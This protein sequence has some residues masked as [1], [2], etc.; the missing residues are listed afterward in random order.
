MTKQKYVK[1]H[2]F[3]EEKVKNQNNCLE[4]VSEYIFLQC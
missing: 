1:M 4:D 3:Q 2:G